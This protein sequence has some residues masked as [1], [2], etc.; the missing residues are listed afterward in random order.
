M[1][2]VSRRSLSRRASHRKWPPGFGGRLAAKRSG[3]TPERGLFR[4]L[5]GWSVDHGFEPRELDV[6]IVDEATKLIEQ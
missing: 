4:R 5:D 2:D 1:Q 6:A 3:A